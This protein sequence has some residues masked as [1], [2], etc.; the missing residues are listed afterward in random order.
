MPTDFFTS[1]TLTSQISTPFH[2]SLT[3]S[4]PDPNNLH[5]SGPVLATSLRPHTLSPPLESDI[6]DTGT[7]QHPS[8]SQAFRHHS[9][10]APQT[11]GT[12]LEGGALTSL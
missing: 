5:L 9:Q 12:V 3:I 6:Q 8:N 4:L 2:C 7:F 1:G 10:R 11:L